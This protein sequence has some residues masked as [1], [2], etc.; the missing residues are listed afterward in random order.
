MCFLPNRFAKF[1]LLLAAACLLLCALGCFGVQK[2]TAK[3]S[4]LLTE[5]PQPTP[6]AVAGAVAK[7]GVL[8]AV[9]QADD[10]A[11]IGE[12]ADLR[13]LD[14]TGSTC[15]DA[16][17]EYIKNVKKHVPDVAVSVVSGS[18]SMAAIEECRQI[19]ADLGVRF[20]VR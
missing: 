15:Y 2:E 10:F 3:A 18:L 6:I 9:V 5:Q 13:T 7:N 1:L 19:A 8:R 12:I 14:V 11:L 4:P 17:L 20:K 16:I